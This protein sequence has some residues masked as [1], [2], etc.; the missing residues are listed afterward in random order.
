[1]IIRLGFSRSGAET[2]YGHEDV[3]PITEV[4]EKHGIE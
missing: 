4:R 1:M 3:L 2:T